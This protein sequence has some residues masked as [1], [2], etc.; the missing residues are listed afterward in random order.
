MPYAVNLALR[1]QIEWLCTYLTVS[2]QLVEMMVGPGRQPVKSAFPVPVP[3]KAPV[4]MSP[5]A[6]KKVSCVGPADLKA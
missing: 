5:V 1:W 2:K 6:M 3:A 4:A